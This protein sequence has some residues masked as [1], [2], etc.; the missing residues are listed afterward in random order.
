MRSNQLSYASVFR[1][2]I[3][4]HIFAFVNRSIAFFWKN[5]GAQKI[6]GAARVC[7][8]AD[9]RLGYWWIRNPHYKVKSFALRQKVKSKA[10]A[11][12]EIVRF[13]HGEMKS[14]LIRR[15]GF[16]RAAISSEQSEDFFRT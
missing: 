12:G 4:H 14:V 7:H 10:H 13:A 6:K 8:H 5:A 16:H 3:I 1:F 11:F 2:V 9:R 15:G